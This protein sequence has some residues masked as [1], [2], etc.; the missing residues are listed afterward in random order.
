MS[1]SLLNRVLG[2]EHLTLVVVMVVFPD[3]AALTFLIL[4]SLLSLSELDEVVQ[5]KTAASIG[6]T[7]DDGPLLLRFVV[8]EPA[9]VPSTLNTSLEAGVLEL[10][11][12]FFVSRKPSLVAG[13][14]LPTSD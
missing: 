1:P 13:E 2:S 10:C 3:G 7:L 5:D 14:Q 11:G 12:F 6:D 8:S 4:E 9:V